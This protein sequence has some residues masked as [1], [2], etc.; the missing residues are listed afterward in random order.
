MPAGR[1]VASS[2]RAGVRKPPGKEP[3][4]TVRWEK[5]KVYGDLGEA[6]RSP[7]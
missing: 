7:W 4:G 5:R 6:A 1:E 3:A 2:A